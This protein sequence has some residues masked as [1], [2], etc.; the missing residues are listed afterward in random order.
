MI[1]IEVPGQPVPKQRSRSFIHRQSGK[2]LH[3]TPERT[4]NYEA[5]VARIG[6]TA[7]V[8]R[9][10]LEGPL[11][12]TVFAH[13]MTPKR[14]KK[15]GDYHTSTPDWDNVGKICSDALNGIVWKDDAQ[16][17]SAQVVKTYAN[18]PKVI[19]EVRPL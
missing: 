6:R 19:I 2:M 3:L 15:D 10:L 12:I 7:M 5:E 17:A 1:R 11:A 4:I 9:D 18:A 8:G 14:G 16:V 13:F